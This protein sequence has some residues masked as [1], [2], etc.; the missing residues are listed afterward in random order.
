VDWDLVLVQQDK[1]NSPPHRDITVLGEV[2]IQ[3]MGEH[4]DYSRKGLRMGERRR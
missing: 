4:K 2:M 1:N 3:W